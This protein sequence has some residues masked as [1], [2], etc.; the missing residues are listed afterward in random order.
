MTEPGRPDTGVDEDAPPAVPAG[1]SEDAP[2]AAD[3]TAARDAEGEAA[4]KGVLKPNPE[5]AREEAGE[6]TGREALKPEAFKDEDRPSGAQ[7]DIVKE[8]ENLDDGP[9]KDFMTAL[10]KFMRKYG[11]LIDFVPGFFVKDAP[12]I[13]LKGDEEARMLAGK[14][15]TEREADALK[16]MK[17]YTAHKEKNAEPIN[18]GKASTRFVALSLWGINNFS[19]PK[20]LAGRLKSAKNPTSKENLYRK[21]EDGVTEFLEASKPEKYTDDKGKERTRPR[22]PYGSILI[23]TE[24]NLGKPGEEIVAYATGNGNEFKYYKD[25]KVETMPL[26]DMKTALLGFGL[27]FKAA[28]I[29]RF[30]SDDEYAKAH[31]EASHSSIAEGHTVDEWKKTVK[32]GESELKA[33]ADWENN[34]EIAVVLKNLDMLKYIASAMVVEDMA[35]EIETMK[36]SAKSSKVNIKEVRKLLERSGSMLTQMHSL[37]FNLEAQKEEIKRQSG[38]K[39]DVD[40]MKS[41]IAEKLKK[42]ESLISS[43]PRIEKSA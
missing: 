38:G 40:E 32:S 39:V 3:P 43:L 26:G 33:A 4:A 21:F 22:Y 8:M 28:F 29:P 41:D 15:G 13:A 14:K 25:G 17:E 27:K 5:A 20:A 35:K 10:A 37:L 36:L 16:F 31:P 42:I 11:M 9:V 7:T 19:D 18:A 1:A 24:N 2:P 34:T 30:N 6:K 23:F 12:E